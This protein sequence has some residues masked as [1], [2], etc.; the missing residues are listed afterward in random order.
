[1]WK[2]G[3]LASLTLLMTSAATQQSQAQGARVSILGCVS[4]G[5]ERGCLI[6]T[7]NVSGKTYQIN[8]ANPKP[9]PAQGLVVSLSGTIVNKAD[10]CQQ[11]PILEKIKWTYTK[12]KCERPKD[13]AKK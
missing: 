7:D 12:K 6:I 9:D 8:A 5:V 1:M 4:Q 10:I 3:A 13:G 11:G 2:F